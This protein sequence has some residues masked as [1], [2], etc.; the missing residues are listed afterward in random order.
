[1]QS[2]TAPQALNQA[3]RRMRRDLEAIFGN[4]VSEHEKACKSKSNSLSCG[5]QSTGSL[6]RFSSNF[7]LHRT[8]CIFIGLS[9]LKV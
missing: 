2:Q 6:T 4:S 7:I 1:M 8:T 5:I 9:W 3:K